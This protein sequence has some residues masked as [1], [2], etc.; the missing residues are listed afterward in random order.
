MKNCIWSFVDAGHNLFST[1][2]IFDGFQFASGMKNT[3]V[4]VAKTNKYLS[5][6]NRKTIPDIS[7]YHSVQVHE[8]GMR[9]W[10]YFSVGV[11]VIILYSN[12]PFSSGLKRVG[13]FKWASNSKITTIETSLSSKKEKIEVYAH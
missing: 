13:K 2:N 3:K 10:W 11:G 1:S 5:V 9:F 4:G 6:L 12:A 7:R 8:N